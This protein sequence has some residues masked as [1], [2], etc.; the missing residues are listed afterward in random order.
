[1]AISAISG[2]TSLDAVYPAQALLNKQA[3][4]ANTGAAEGAGGKPAGGPKG[5]PPAGGGG[6][7]ASGAGGASGAS[8]NSQIYDPRDLNKDGV[9]SPEE[10]L[11]YSLKH[12]GEQTNDQTA[13]QGYN[14]QGQA[15][16]ATNGGANAA[17]TFSLMA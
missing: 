10:A 12:P 11:E 6:G 2:L 4:A 9:V 15:V 17:N 5:A 16:G 7:K 1:M 8:D 14:Q 3:A 13:A